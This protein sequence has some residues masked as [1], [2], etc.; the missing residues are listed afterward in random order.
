MFTN[1]I[2]IEFIEK[3]FTHNNIVPCESCCWHHLL[4]CM[5]NEYICIK[6]SCVM[7]CSYVP[8]FRTRVKCML[9]GS[10]ISVGSVV[11]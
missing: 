10:H 2:K 3:S 11:S 8:A 4:I 6:L 5:D 7:I 9:M 1:D